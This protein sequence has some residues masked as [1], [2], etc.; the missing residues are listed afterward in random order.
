MSG[1]AQ[2]KG[3]DKLIRRLHA[4]PA[5]VKKVGDDLV[6]KH[7]RALISSS[8]KNKGLVQI[9]PPSQGRANATAK[10]TGEKAV[11]RDIKR[12]FAKSSYVYDT[13]KNPAAKAAFWILLKKRKW[14]DARRIVEA[15]SYNVRLKNATIVSRPDASLHMSARGKQG[16]VKSSQH[17]MQIIANEG[18]L[19]AYIRRRQ[20]N[21]G[22][23]AASLVLMYDARFGAL[24][25]VPGWV[26]RHTR[27]FASSRMTTLTKST[28]MHIRIEFK[29]GAT[30][31]AMQRFFTAA[32]R[33]RLGVMQREAPHALRGYMKSLQL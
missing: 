32:A 18:S 26:R 17:V 10:K 6:K 29:A 14:E 16:R 1:L 2:I 22:M 25:G 3:M 9:V 12:V 21:V 31:S 5:Q 33:F 8:G 30:S 7:T 19:N 11:A 24:A 15:E 23:A 27:S 13:I 20:K 28:G 4:T